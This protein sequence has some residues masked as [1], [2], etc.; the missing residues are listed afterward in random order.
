LVSIHQVAAQ[1]LAK[2]SM[3]HSWGCHREDTPGTAALCIGPPPGEIN[4]DNDSRGE[5]TRNIFPT[6]SD[7]QDA[8]DFAVIV[9]KRRSARPFRAEQVDHDQRDAMQS[10][11]RLDSALCEAHIISERVTNHRQVQAARRWRGSEVEDVAWRR[12]G[13]LQRL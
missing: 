1:A 12:S 8:N 7:L 6:K 5:F 10:Q 9:D 2:G 3:L 11:D 13:E 4:A